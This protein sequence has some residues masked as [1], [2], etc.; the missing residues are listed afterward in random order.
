MLEAGT[1][2]RFTGAGI[3]W[4]NMQSRLLSQLHHFIPEYSHDRSMTWEFFKVKTKR[5]PAAKAP[6]FCGMKL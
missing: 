2:Q 1:V 3:V 4:C 5:A 6:S